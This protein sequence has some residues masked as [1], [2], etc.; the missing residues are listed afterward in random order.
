MDKVCQSG[1]IGQWPSPQP[2]GSDSPRA[3][4]HESPTVMEILFSLFYIYR[5]QTKFAKVMFLHLS[6]SYS[7]HGRGEGV[8]IHGWGSASSGVLHPREGEY[9]SG[10]RVYIQG[11]GGLHPR[12]R[13]FAS[14][15]IYIWGGGLQPGKGVCIQRVGVGHTATPDTTGYG[16]RVGGTHPTGMHSC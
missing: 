16:Q 11:R 5:P 14:G 12:E 13:E 3:R 8:C 10:E 9:V 6:V 4:D 2:S 15:G 1:W 7:V